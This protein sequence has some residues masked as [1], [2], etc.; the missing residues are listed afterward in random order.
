MKPVIHTLTALAALAVTSACSEI[1]TSI[2]VGTSQVQPI[3]MR[4]IGVWKFEL[5]DPTNNS[6]DADVVVFPSDDGAGLEAIGV[7]ADPR[8][9][10]VDWVEYRVITGKIGDITYA[11]M[12]QL[13]ENGKP[14]EKPENGFWPLLYRFETDG[15]IRLFWWSEDGVKSAV[16]A[17]ENRNIKGEHTNAA[18]HFTADARTL[19]AFFAQMGPAML[20]APIFSLRPLK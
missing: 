1:T 15:S 7:A 4:L 16:D 14:D 9:K 6:E 12:R 20:S 2:P 5:A 19:D 17:I 18:A 3:D 10:T 13:G 8:T 11:S